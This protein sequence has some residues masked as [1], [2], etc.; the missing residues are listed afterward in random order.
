[1]APPSGTALRLGV[2]GAKVLPPQPGP[3]EAYMYFD[4]TALNSLYRVPVSFAALQKT[5]G[6][7]FLGNVMGGDDFALDE[8]E[9]VAYV[10]SEGDNALIRLPL[11]GGQVGPVIG[12][13][14]QT[15]V[16]VGPTSVAVGRRAAEEGQIFVSTNGGLLAPINGTF[17]EGGKVVAVDTKWWT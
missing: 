9:G 14:S 16:G 7:Q 1:M 2:N 15:V 11:S 6:V 13:L 4:N 3:G 12:G 10:A 8:R 5:G 17:T